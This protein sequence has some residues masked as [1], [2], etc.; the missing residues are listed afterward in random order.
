[1]TFYQNT[2]YIWLLFLSTVF[3]TYYSQ[4]SLQTKLTKDN[5][6]Q[7]VHVLLDCIKSSLVQN[8]SKKKFTLYG[9]LQM[10][11]EVSFL[12]NFFSSEAYG[13]NMRGHFSKLVEI[14]T[15]LNVEIPKDCLDLLNHHSINWHLSQSEIKE[16]LTK[17]VEF[18]SNEIRGLQ[19]MKSPQ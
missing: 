12:G 6:I 8:Y 10:Q 11:N 17:R 9:A 5:Y 15:I 18:D 2:K 13:T 3:E 19:I 4:N 7:L 14:V 16:W 1:M